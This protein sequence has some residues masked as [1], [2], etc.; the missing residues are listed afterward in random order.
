MQERWTG[1]KTEI[2]RGTNKSL[3]GPQF[4]KWLQ[5]IIAEN[6]NRTESMPFSWGGKKKKKYRCLWLRYSEKTGCFPPPS[7]SSKVN[8]KPLE[9]CPER[10][11]CS[12][13]PEAYEIIYLPVLCQITSERRGKRDSALQSL[14]ACLG[15]LKELSNCVIAARPLKLYI[16]MIKEST[17]SWS[18]AS[19]PYPTLLW[20]AN[21]LPLNR[22][23]KKKRN[24]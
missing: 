24:E 23:S 14:L 7:P 21:L 20:Q 1:V 17:W 19:K 11:W 5:R 3:R 10:L 4:L 13:K 16:S 12:W 9:I 15:C 2:P 8:C 22:S 6:Y 18:Q